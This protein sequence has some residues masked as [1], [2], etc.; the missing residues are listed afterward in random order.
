MKIKLTE[1]QYKIIILKEGFSINQLFD[2]YLYLTG[3]L[4]DIIAFYKNH[5]D[6][7][8]LDD[9]DDF[10]M[11]NLEKIQK[12]MRKSIA[13]NFIKRLKKNPTEKQM[14]T[15]FKDAVN[16]TYNNDRFLNEISAHIKSIWANLPKKLKTL[17]NIG[18]AITSDAS[19]KEGIKYAIG[20]LILNDIMAID[21]SV[22]KKF[23]SLFEPAWTNNNK[24]PWGA[25]SK[26]EDHIW[27]A[28][29][30]QGKGPFPYNIDYVTNKI[31]NTLDN[32]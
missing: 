1:E 23:K 26:I 31:F 30:T 6:P 3:D 9:L 4:D 10:D 19:V 29:E 13:N 14:I 11:T 8:Y 28:W 15:A 2:E 20:E 18:W 7:E 22:T 16:E 32:L 5:I 25:S 24:Y 17:A 27:D 12:E 21:N